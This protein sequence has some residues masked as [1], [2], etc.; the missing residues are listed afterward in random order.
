M[1][2]IRNALRIRLRTRLRYA[3]Q[4]TQRFDK[5]RLC[6][7]KSSFVKF[8]RPNTFSFSLLTVICCCTSMIFASSASADR[9]PLAGWVQLSP[10][11]SPPARSYLAMTYDPVN[12][13]IIMF[14]GYDGNS[15]LNDTWVF[16]GATW[17]Q[18]TTKTPRPHRGPNGL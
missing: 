5:I 17:T 11:A 8:T 13:K 16:D 3:A 10:T 2:D 9:S 12:G 6:R 1:A 15:Y 7:S 4:R 14:G 18:I